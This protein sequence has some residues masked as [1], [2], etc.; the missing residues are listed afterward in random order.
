MLHSATF[1]LFVSMAIF[2]MAAG[3]PIAKAVAAAL[4]ARREAV[5]AE[6]S[7]AERL[8]AEAQELLLLCQRQHRDALQ[9][10]A[11][12]IAQAREDAQRIRDEAEKNLQDLLKNREDQALA[13]IA[14]AE[15]MATRAA[16]ELATD[17]A[18][19]T[20]RDY[21]KSHLQGA[22]ADALVER[23]IAEMPAKI[24]A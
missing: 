9:E 4:D 7:E 19:G 11:E 1:W 6:I 22:E 2:L 17:L 13:R 20:C 14:E 16:R 8:R 5:R 21:L 15:A 18:L 12:I 24:S 23:A 3:K 10:S